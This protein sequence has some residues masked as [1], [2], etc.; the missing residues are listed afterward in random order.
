M[1]FVFVL[2]YGV[3]LAVCK[4]NLLDISNVDGFPPPQ[5]GWFVC[6]IKGC[7]GFVMV[8]KVWDIVRIWRGRAVW[9]CHNTF[10]ARHVG[11]R[12]GRRGWGGG[13]LAFGGEMIGLRVHVH[14]DYASQC[15]CRPAG[16]NCYVIRRGKAKV[17]GDSLVRYRVNK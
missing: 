17:R 14:G 15:S 2:P 8:N 16:A 13:S 9:V 10:T 4:S 3:K 7:G 11:E 12:W 5:K 1:I 6:G